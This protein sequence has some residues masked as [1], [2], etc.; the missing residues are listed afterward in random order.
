[1]IKFTTTDTLRSYE[2]VKQSVIVGDHDVTGQDAALTPSK[3]VKKDLDLN[4][5]LKQ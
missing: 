5:L 1:M 4:D 3:T 2:N